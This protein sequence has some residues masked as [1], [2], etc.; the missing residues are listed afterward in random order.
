MKHQRVD[1]AAYSRLFAVKPTVLA[2]FLGE[3]PDPAGNKPMIQG[4]NIISLAEHRKA[5]ASDVECRHG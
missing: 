1:L 3:L 4:S 5:V 2:E